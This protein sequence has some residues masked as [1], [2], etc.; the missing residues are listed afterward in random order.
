MGE[1]GHF[2]VIEIFHKINVI[3]K[4]QLKMKNNVLFVV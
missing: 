4:V 2:L 1:N 3:H